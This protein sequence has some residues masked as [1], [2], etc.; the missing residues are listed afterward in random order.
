MYMSYDEYFS[1]SSFLIKLHEK[2][3]LIENKVKIFKSPPGGVLT[4]SN[5]TEFT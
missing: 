4:F 1:H 2:L 3:K 5:I